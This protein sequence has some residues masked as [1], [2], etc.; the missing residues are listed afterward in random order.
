[1]SE[2][3]NNWS[4]YQQFVIAELARLNT[5]LEGLREDMVE[6]RTNVAEKQGAFKAV[7][8]IISACTAVVATIVYHL[9]AK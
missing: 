6:L 9:L 1:M 5:T 4:K 2:N 3:E 8:A 7:T